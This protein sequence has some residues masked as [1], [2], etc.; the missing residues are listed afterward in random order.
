MTVRIPAQ[1][2]DL[3]DLLAEMESKR[4]LDVDWRGGRA[5]S[6][7]YHAG[8]AHDHLLKRAHNAWFS[9]NALNPMAFKS[10]KRMESELVQMTAS[11]LH[12]PPTACGTL[13]SGG[14]ESILLAVKAARD[15]ARRRRPWVRRPEMVLPRTAHVAF[16][17]AGELF[18]VRPRWVPVGADHRADVGAM[19][20]AIGRRTVLVA[21]SAPQY[22][23]GVVD[24]IEELAPLASKRDLPF[25]VD[26]C[27]GG[28]ILP[29]LEKLGHVPPR[30]DFRVPGVT[31]ISADLHKYG[32]TCKGTSVLLY[33]SMDYL[34]HQFFASTDWPGG[35]YAS[36]GL[37]GSRPGGPIAAAWASL[38]G[39]GEDGFLALAKRSWDAAE[40]LRS[41]VRQIS[42]LRVVGAPH[43]TIVTWT[44][45]ELSVYAIADRLEA[46]G[47][48]AERQQ[49]PPTVHCTVAAHHAPVVERYLVDLQACVAEVRA[50]P[51]LAQE[52]EAP[53]YGMMARLP[54]RR[55]VRQGVIQLMEQMY[56]PGAAEI[57][58]EDLSDADG[59]LLRLIHRYGPR[60]LDVLER[61]PGAGASS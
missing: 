10:L 33:R 17:K 24:P 29:W 44:S 60:L 23:H 45:D 19:A 32:Y 52:G 5:W 43:S 16:D 27:F 50:N 13:T 2:R 6:L 57:D 31:S 26:A 54:V 21:A 15:R 9:E 46:R 8:D 1:G 20:K 12:A 40:V 35:V 39:L 41:G 48:T 56:A 14:T 51:D 28:F 18:G 49:R 34:R 36:P 42:G 25:H 3:D 30:W 4:T 53:L 58:L 37:L 55:L 11:M 59:P 61:V 22:P 47:W 38:Q 7:V